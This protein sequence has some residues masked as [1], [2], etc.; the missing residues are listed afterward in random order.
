MVAWLSCHHVAGNRRRSRVPTNPPP[1]AV[2][3]AMKYALRQIGSSGMRWLVLAL[4]VV[5]CARPAPQYTTKAAPFWQT[6]QR[7]LPG[8][9]A[10]TTDVGVQVE[11]TFRT[12]SR[13]SAL[14][15]T[16]GRPGKETMTLYHP[17]RGDIV[18]THYCGQGNAPR[19]RVTSVD[20]KR[21]V[22][23]QTDVTDLG[24]D[25]ASLVEMEITLGDGWFDR[26]EVYR[27]AKGALDRTRWH[28][29]RQ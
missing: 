20:G 6:M 16:F 18:A 27:D 25:E 17:D 1:D 2:L 8:T 3:A 4:L 5:A 10:G 14:A 12:I 24:A 22:W 19:L 29:V 7:T 13:A 15:E 9:W 28:F 21:V 11:V 26:V 23:K